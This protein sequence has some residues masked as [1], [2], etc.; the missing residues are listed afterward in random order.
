MGA[1]AIVEAA[2]EQVRSVAA[3]AP[4]EQVSGPDARA[5]VEALARLEKAAGGARALYAATVAATGAYRERGDTDPARWLSQV[6]GEPVGRARQ[7]LE[8]AEA[9]AETPSLRAALLSGEVSLPQVQLAAPA[10]LGDPAAEEQLLQAAKGGTF[11]ELA[12]LATRTARA[13]TGEAEAQERE[14]RL[15]AR[16]YCRTFTPP[17]GGLRLEAHLPTADGA[18]VKAV[19]DALTAQVFAEARQVDRRE[20]IERYRADALVR[21]MAGGRDGVRVRALLR[22]DAAALRRG[23]LEPGE[24]CE[25][26]GVGTI[27]LRAAHELLGEALCHVVVHDLVD[28]VAVSRQT[29]VRTFA[30]EIALMERDPLCVV[31][32]CA[33]AAPLQVD[34]WRRDYAKGGRTA[35]DNLCRL[36]PEHHAMKTHRG[37]RLLGG[38]GAWR[39]LGPDDPGDGAAQAP[40]TDPS[41]RAPTPPRG[42]TGTTPTP[43]SPRAPGNEAPPD[44]PNAGP[45]AGPRAGATRNGKDPPPPLPLA[46]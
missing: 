12:T 18:R 37:W 15:Q 23:R 9:L 11:T 42:R 16:R 22:G 13:K 45:R 28:V 32:G 1:L 7:T 39:F 33:V 40:A 5:M 29:R 20:P 26:A 2:I 14:R 41:G 3:L 21:A 25:I 8:T 4:P 17:E 44:S 46:G 27:S 30:Q 36:C 24:V 34:H 35:L 38:P 19:L 43:A 31:P 6:T 10:A